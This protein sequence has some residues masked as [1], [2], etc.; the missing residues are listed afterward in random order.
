VSSSDRHAS[1]PDAVMLNSP[2]MAARANDT[3]GRRALWRA[4]PHRTGQS[5][6]SGAARLL[7]LLLAPVDA[8][9]AGAT[10]A[11]GRA[12]R[13]RASCRLQLRSCH[14]LRLRAIARASRLLGARYGATR[15]RRGGE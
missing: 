12:W 8:Q 5:A 9:R 2:A 1:E 10:R 3:D 4:V 13:A 6:P 11:E 14:R 15:V 7:C